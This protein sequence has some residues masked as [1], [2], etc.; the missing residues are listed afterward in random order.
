MREDATLVVNNA[1]EDAGHHPEED[2]E[3]QD[4]WAVSGSDTTDA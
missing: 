2:L 4:F 3:K 1:G